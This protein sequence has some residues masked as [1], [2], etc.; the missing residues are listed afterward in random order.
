MGCGEKSSSFFRTV[1]QNVPKKGWEGKDV[2]REQG[3]AWKEGLGC[4]GFEVDTA[5]RRTG[6]VPAA[7]PCQQLL[8]AVSGEIILIINGLVIGTSSAIRPRGHVLIFGVIPQRGAQNLEP[9]GA[10]PVPTGWP[11]PYKPSCFPAMYGAGEA[12]NGVGNGPVT[13]LWG[14]RAPKA[15]SGAAKHRVTATHRVLNSDFPLF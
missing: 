11:Q 2:A 14:G 7:R 12:R 1:P 8:A 9:P 15:T 10:S 3:A 5:Q 4:A 13:S 6:S